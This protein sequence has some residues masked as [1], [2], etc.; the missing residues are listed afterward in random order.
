[1][2]LI[3]ALLIPS[4]SVTVCELLATFSAWGAK[5]SEAGFATSVTLQMTVESTVTELLVSSG[6]RKLEPLLKS[7]FAVLA[8]VEPQVAAGSSVPVMEYVTDAFA[9]NVTLAVLMLPVPDASQVAPPEPTQVQVAPVTA[10]G[11]LS[12]TVGASAE[13]IG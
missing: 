2:L 9:G 5:L 8:T 7:A 1:M 12:T 3:L 6:S 13:S 10:A 4:V 11:T